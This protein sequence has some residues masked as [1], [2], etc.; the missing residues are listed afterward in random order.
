LAAV[1]LAIAS[2]EDAA[3]AIA[4]LELLGGA[5]GRVQLAGKAPAGAHVFVDYAHTPDALSNV[6]TALRPH[7][8]KRLH[9]VFG[10]GG[11]RDPGKRPEMG[12][13]AQD[14]ADVVIVTDDNPRTEDAAQIRAQVLAA[15]PSAVEIGDREEA[16]TEAIRGLDLGDLLVIAGKG[17]EKGQI[18]GTE[19]RPFND[20]Q[21][22]RDVIRRLT[23]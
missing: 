18:I 10:C 13:I 12:A 5:P 22:A 3:E 23:L 14:L 9:V 20:I 15:A 11:D 7:A 21:V 16:I 1:A 4:Q 19:T 17:H 2:G 8:A 6:L